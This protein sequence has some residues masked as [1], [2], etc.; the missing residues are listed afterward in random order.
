MAQ[1]LKLPNADKYEA[2]EILL[3]RTAR[4]VN[5]LEKIKEKVL[6]SMRSEVDVDGCKLMY[7]SNIK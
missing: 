3:D 4:Q 6:E 5:V 7:V 1:E 2:Q